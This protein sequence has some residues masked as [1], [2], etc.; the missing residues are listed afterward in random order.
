MLCIECKEPIRKGQEYQ[1]LDTARKKVIHESCFNSILD[2]PAPLEV[3]K[4]KGPKS[5]EWMI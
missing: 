3:E 4:T 2:R 1:V 5:R